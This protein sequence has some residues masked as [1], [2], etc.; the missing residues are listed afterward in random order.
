MRSVSESEPPRPQVEVSDE[1][2]YLMVPVQMV[3]EEIPKTEMHV[4]C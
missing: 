2:I 1:M 4:A 3:P